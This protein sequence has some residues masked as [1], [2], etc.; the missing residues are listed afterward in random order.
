MANN[1]EHE[2]RALFP[3]EQEGT[4]P[5][6]QQWHA[7]EWYL[8]VIDMVRVLTESDI[9]RN[10]WSDLKRRLAQDEGFIELHAKIV[11]LK[12]RALD[13][14]MRATDAANTATLLRIIESIPSPKAEPVKQWLA[15]LG[16]QR[17]YDALAERDE[18]QRRLLIRGE[19]AEKNTTL[20]SAAARAGVITQRDFAIF[21]DSGYQGMYNG[22]GEN[23]IHARMGLAKGEK[24]LNWMGSEALAANLFRITQAEAKLRRDPTITTKEQANQTHYDMGKAVRQ[25]IAD[26]GGTMPEDLPPAGQSIQQLERLEQKRLAAERQPSLFDELPEPQEPEQA[27]G[28]GNDE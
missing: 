12:M 19:V 11:Q 27:E 13:G 4:W 22:L 14:R 2:D 16:A 6:R 7:G 23:G 28:D 9:P 21:H 24:I 3:F 18:A 20:N 25:F 10:Y 26:Q 1:D 17:L 8:S 5:I 15:Q